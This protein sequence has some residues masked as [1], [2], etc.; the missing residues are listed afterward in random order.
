LLLTLALF[1][2]VV[3]HYACTSSH[4]HLGASS[5]LATT[6]PSS[7][8]CIALAPLFCLRQRSAALLQRRSDSPHLECLGE[9]LTLSGRASRSTTGTLRSTAARCASPSP[10]S[11]SSRGAGPSAARARSAR[12]MTPTCGTASPTW[13]FAPRRVPAMTTL[14]R[15]SSPLVTHYVGGLAETSVCWSTLRSGSLQDCQGTTSQRVVLLPSVVRQRVAQLLFAVAVLHDWVTW[16]F[17]EVKH[18]R[19]FEGL[20]SDKRCRNWCDRESA[21]RFRRFSIDFAVVEADCRVT[22]WSTPTL[23]CGLRNKLNPYHRST[24]LQPSVAPLRQ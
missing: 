12:P 24:R 13:L 4:Y 6:M 8:R 15:A 5:T 23:S 16:I 11:S 7:L 1:V 22:A 20:G 3:T 14:S 2:A 21:V 18:A 9:G 17:K 19:S 10:P